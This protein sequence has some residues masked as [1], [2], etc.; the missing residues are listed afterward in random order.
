MTLHIAVLMG[1]ISA[2]RAVSLASGAA[3]ARALAAKGYRVTS[4]DVTSRHFTLPEGTDLAFI[5]LHGTY[6]ED[7]EIQAE[8]ARRGV[9]F[10]GSGEASSRAAFDKVLS[11]RCFERAGIHTPRYE[12]LQAGQPRTLSLPVVVKPPRQGSSLGLAKVMHEAEWLPALAKAL[13]YD[14]EV[15]VEAYIPGRELTV[16][17]VAGEVLPVVE[18]RAPDGHYDYKAKYTKGATEY[19][20]PAPLEPA[21]A[22]QCQ[23]IAWDTFVALEASGLGRV[24][25]RLTDDG[26]PFVLELNSI[27]GFTETSLLPKAAAAAGFSFADLCD[28]I[29]RHTCSPPA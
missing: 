29:V 5:A 22:K 11:K 10:T 3:I 7:G 23:Q 9:A 15:L 13:E 8:L 21:V 16:G 1:G 14:H 28:K 18:I 24:D 4:V 2:E 17:I 6:G 26:I 19:L 25:I 20:C 27:P 12:V